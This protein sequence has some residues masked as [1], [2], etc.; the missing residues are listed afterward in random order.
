MAMGESEQVAMN[1]A[2][3]IR[4][5]RAIRARLGLSAG[6]RFVVETLDDGEIRL[7]PVE[8]TAQ[9]VEKEGVLVVQSVAAGELEGIEKRARE[10]RLDDL[11]R[12]VG[13]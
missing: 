11:S 9:L 3:Q 10:E 5:P 4:I 13:Q 6:T 12:S 7:R 8:E 2:G 1:R